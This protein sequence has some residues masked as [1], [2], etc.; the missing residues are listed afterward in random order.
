MSA[1]G[2]EIASEMRRQWAFMRR[3]QR[4]Y[5]SNFGWMKAS[6]HACQIAPSGA[7]MLAAVSCTI[8]LSHCL[9]HRR[10]LVAS[11]TKHA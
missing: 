11:M 4:A 6:S 9:S 5:V 8:Y 1:K 2:N 3:Y 7:V 10:S